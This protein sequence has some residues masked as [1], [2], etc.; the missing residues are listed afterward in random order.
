[1]ATRTAAA[2][3]LDTKIDDMLTALD[4]YLAL[5][6]QPGE[7]QNSVAEF[8]MATLIAKLGTRTRMKPLIF[9]NKRDLRAYSAAL[10]P[11]NTVEA[12]DPKA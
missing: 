4:S 2:Q 12:R 8:F 5:A 1:M 9:S 6:A 3:T 10:L 7:P 11:T